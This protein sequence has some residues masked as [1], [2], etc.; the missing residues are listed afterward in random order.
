MQLWN[1]AHNILGVHLFDLLTVIALVAAALILAIHLVKNKY[2]AAAE[3]NEAA[4]DNAAAPKE[5][6]KA[7]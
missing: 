1:F 2:N 6:S 4:A 3:T 7:Q 5:G